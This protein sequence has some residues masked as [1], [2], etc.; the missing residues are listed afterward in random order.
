MKD[1]LKK[2]IASYLID[3]LK[4]EK[5]RK[6]N[7]NKNS[8]PPL[9]ERTQQR[10]GAPPP[11][12]QSTNDLGRRVHT[13]ESYAYFPFSVSRPPVVGK[14]TLTHSTRFSG[15]HLRPTHPHPAGRT[16]LA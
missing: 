15:D 4:N 9:P 3:H 2:I 8:H 14:E 12:P 7:D 6:R 16:P 10:I 1:L 5:K 11:P 13:Y